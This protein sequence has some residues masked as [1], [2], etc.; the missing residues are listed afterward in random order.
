MIKIITIRP[1][2][3]TK[4]QNLSGTDDA[5]LMVTALMLLD[6]FLLRPE[7]WR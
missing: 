6:P 3:R 5:A 1:Y 4:E 2:R 7:S